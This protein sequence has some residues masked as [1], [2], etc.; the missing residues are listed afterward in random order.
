MG[1]ELQYE[2]LFKEYREKRKYSA[3]RNHSLDDREKLFDTIQKLLKDYDKGKTDKLEMYFEDSQNP[4]RN[5]LAILVEFDEFINKKH[6]VSF[7]DIPEV[8]NLYSSH[9]ERHL[10]LLKEMHEPK[11]VSEL[12]ETLHINE[13]T[14]NHYIKD[15]EN[16]YMFMDSEIKVHIHREHRQDR[17]R[18]VVHP[19][20][21]ALNSTELSLLLSYLQ[22][23]NDQVIG[24][25]GN[26]IYSQLTEYA[27]KKICPNV[28]AFSDSISPNYDDEFYRTIAAD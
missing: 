25:I 12:A 14:A 18:S 21:L 22:E 2:P 15:L 9:I 6:G 19:V 20:F 10:Q 1:Q 4:K 27:K 17:C 3:N 24:R 7:P 5:A 16:G 13:S 11:K 26:L 28:T 23:S 8:S